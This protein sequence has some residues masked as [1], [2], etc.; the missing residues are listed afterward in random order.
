MFTDASFWSEP[1]EEAPRTARVLACIKKHV[2]TKNLLFFVAKSFNDNSIIYMF[3]NGNVVANWIQVQD[4]DIGSRTDLNP[5]E[6]AFLGCNVR[7]VDGRILIQMYQEQ[8]SSRVFEI[9]QDAKGNPAVIGVINGINCRVE[10]AYAQMKK[11]PVPEAE[12]L[13]LYGRSLKD[14]SSVVEKISA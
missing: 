12:Y 10:R 4:K 2:N 7:E 5:A 8:L 11:G 6:A 9:V 1:A 13:N 14:G 3:E